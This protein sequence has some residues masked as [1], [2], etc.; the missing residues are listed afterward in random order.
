MVV[1]FPV[2]DRLYMV[3]SYFRFSEEMEVHSERMDS[4]IRELKDVEL[5]V[6]ADINARSSL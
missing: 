3:N 6:V 2:G 5:L 4:L 1:E